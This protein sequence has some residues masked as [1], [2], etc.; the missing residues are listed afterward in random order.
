MS[1]KERAGSAMLKIVRPVVAALA[2]LGLIALVGA[3]TTSK[4][5]GSAPMAA[6]PNVVCTTEREVGSHVP[7]RTCRSRAQSAAEREAAQ[8]AMDSLRR[9]PIT[10]SP[11]G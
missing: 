9:S 11:Q 8:D 7:K 2:L 5:D 10:P 4:V 6:Q 3:C 1:N